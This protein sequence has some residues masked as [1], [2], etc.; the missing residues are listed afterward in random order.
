MNFAFPVKT[1]LFVSI[2]DLAKA[3]LYIG[4][5]GILTV[6][7]KKIIKLDSE[8]ITSEANP[9]NLFTKSTISSFDTDIFIKKS[10]KKPKNAKPKLV[11]KKFICKPIAWFYGQKYINIDNAYIVVQKH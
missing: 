10:K 5:F 8:D 4:N 3:W 2:E 11:K 7:S 1:L 9:N 6:A